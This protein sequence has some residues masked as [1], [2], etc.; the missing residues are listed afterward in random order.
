L[1]CTYK[2]DLPDAT[3]RVNTATVAMPNHNYTATAPVK[4]GDPT[5]VIDECITVT[6][7]KYGSQGTVCVGNQALP[8]TFPRYSLEI[9][10]YTL[11][12]CGGGPYEFTNCGS[13]VTNDTG[14]PGQDCW[15]VTVTVPCPGCTYTQGYWKTHS[16]YG[17]APYDQEGWAKLGDFD[18]DGVAKEADEM[19]FSGGTWYNVFT[20]APKGGNAWYILAHQFMAAYLNVANGAGA[21]AMVIAALGEAYALLENKNPATFSDWKGSAEAK[22]MIELAGILDQYNNGYGG[23]P[24]CGDEPM[25]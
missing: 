13:F 7:D 15:T 3:E 21:D 22:R 8:Y 20:T 11:E 4:F 17:P 5:E 1:E 24:H 18:G 2:A 6:D 10:P 9:G 14:T 23:V 12:Q 25:P 19:L 16:S